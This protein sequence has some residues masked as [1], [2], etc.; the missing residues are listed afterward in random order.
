MTTWRD[1]ASPIISRVIY[2]VGRGDM[3]K[4]RKALRDAYPFGE[5]KYHPY[6]IWC[7]EV[8]RQLGI[9]GGPCRTDLDKLDDFNRRNQET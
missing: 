7:D 2:E 8:R 3:K 1:H 5:R 6:K 4:L 9:K